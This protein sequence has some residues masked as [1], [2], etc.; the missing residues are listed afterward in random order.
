[1]K[2]STLSFDTLVRLSLPSFLTDV[3]FEHAGV[4]SAAIGAG[5]E[6]LLLVTNRAYER[7]GIGCVKKN[8]VRTK[9]S[10]GQ[11]RFAQKETV[12]FDGYLNGIGYVAF[13]AKS[14]KSE[15]KCWRPDRRFLHQFLFLLRGQRQMPREQAR[16][17]Y[18]IEHRVVDDSR[19]RLEQASK[20]YLVE[21]LEAIR[22]SGKYEFRDED[23]VGPGPHG[24]IL[25]YRAKLKETRQQ[26]GPSSQ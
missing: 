11:M 23:L 8:Y 20:I 13:D 18:V 19:G 14:V 25:D 6:N 2:R 17:F 4:R 26:T 16:F 22:I 5:L 1:M 9:L 15:M 7:A 10:H 12:D 3:G 24:A 21:D